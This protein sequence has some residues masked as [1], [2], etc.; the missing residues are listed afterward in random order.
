MTKSSAKIQE[1][2]YGVKLALLLIL[3][4]MI[5]SYATYNIMEQYMP[6]NFAILNIAQKRV[7]LLKSL[8]TEKVFVKYGVGSEIYEERIKKFADFLKKLSYDVKIIKTDKIKSLQSG[9]KLVLIDTLAL[10]SGVKEDIKSFLKKGGNLLFNYNVAFSD[11]NAKFI[12][13]RF[14][15]SITGLKFSKDYNYLDLKKEGGYLTPKLLSPVTLFNTK[16][17]RMD[18]VLYDNIPVF[19][20]PSFLEPDVLLTN[21]TQSQ[22]PLIDKTL[23]MISLKKAGMMWHG[24]YEKGKW[25]YFNFP[26]YSFFEA[27]KS[28]PYFEKL[29]KGA[30]NFLQKDVIIR[31]YPFLDKENVMFT[32]EDTE[33]KF[34]NLLRFSNLSKKYDIPVTAFLVGYLTKEYPGIVKKAS[35]NPLLEF[36][37][38]SFSHK[39]I[40]GQSDDY[41]KK[42]TIGSKK[43]I[44][45]IS[46]KKV[47]G[48][49]PPREEID[50]KME[51]YLSKGGYKYVMEKEKDVLFP[52]MNDENL[53]T[54]PRHG[55]DD[56]TY[57]MN[58]DW[59][60]KTITN[61]ILKEA[62]VLRY[63]NGIYTLSVHTHLISYGS[64]INIL[65]NFFKFLK[66]HP[67]FSPLSGYEL[68]K[69]VLLVKNIDITWNIT[70]K[71]IIVTVKNANP[72][73]IKDFTFKIYPSKSIVLDTI[74]SEM[75]GVVLDYKKLD[76]DT[77]TVKVADIKPHS[78]LTF[79]IN[80]HERN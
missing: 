38:H 2:Y 4:S 17:K 3:L 14:L 51:H 67:D 24:Y 6:K 36:G 41:V 19:D 21:Y 63:L 12:G 26:S 43:V 55:I 72:Q 25:V 49:R 53:M 70:N 29:I 57:L 50:K 62:T 23:S 22:T 77:Y 35:Q 60:Q 7:Y 47:R 44:E 65:E 18:L 10:E 71:N 11:E 32:S 75:S 59:D 68:Y 8:S 37:S 69:R 34:E 16:G 74:A 9:D 80:Y 13:D 45:Q 27:P 1:S 61:Q 54:I 40:T 28:T 76:D 66:E 58:L 33:Y 78:S 30:F 48:F 31:K 42:E 46:G 56:Y 79:F 39:K 73:N 20:A 5:F 15:N 64:N 52:F